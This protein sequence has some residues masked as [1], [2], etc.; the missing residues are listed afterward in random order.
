LSLW[1][2]RN[3]NSADVKGVALSHIAELDSKIRELELMR[4]TLKKLAHDCHG[5]E[6]PECPILEEFASDD[7]S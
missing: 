5:D 7:R 6:R 3:R 1:Q 2:D 4:N